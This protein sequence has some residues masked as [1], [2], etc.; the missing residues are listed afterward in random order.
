MSIRSHRFV[1][2]RVLTARKASF[3]PA[4]ARRGTLDASAFERGTR[5]FERA[6]HSPHPKE[7]TVNTTMPREAMRR[8][9]VVVGVDLTDVSEHLMVTARN[10]VHSARDAELHVVHV[11]PPEALSLRLAEPLGSFGIADRAQVEAAQWQLQR[12]CDDI[13]R[14]ANVRAVVHTPVGSAARELLRIAS[15]VRANVIVVEAHERRGLRRALHRSLVA[16]VARSAPCSVLAIH[17][18]V[19]TSADKGAAHAAA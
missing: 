2:G 5:V 19:P 10:L 3:D 4:G 11:V 1:G 8:L 7:G 17:R 16:R 15:D 18:R 9:V 6:L 13:V 14:A 12:L